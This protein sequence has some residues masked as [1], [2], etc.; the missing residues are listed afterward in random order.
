[1]KTMALGRP[2]RFEARVETHLTLK[3]SAIHLVDLAAKAEDRNPQ[4]CV[5]QLMD[6]A[7]LWCGLS[8]HIRVPPT[9]RIVTG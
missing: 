2:G 9:T 8:T 3:R 5:P 6:G 4:E 7:R 1:M